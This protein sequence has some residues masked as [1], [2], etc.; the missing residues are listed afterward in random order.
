[1]LLVY[2]W[3][4]ECVSTWFIKN[5]DSG[6]KVVGQTPFV[7][8]VC[9]CLCAYAIVFEIVSATGIHCE[10]NFVMATTRSLLAYLKGLRVGGM[11]TIHGTM[12]VFANK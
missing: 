8:H 5:L 10:T 6:T 3:C 2:V 7:L 11:G 12:K 9:V 4:F 1:M